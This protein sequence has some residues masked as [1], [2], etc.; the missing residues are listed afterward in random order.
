MERVELEACP[1]PTITHYS[2]TPDTPI[3]MTNV[4]SQIRKECHRHS[5]NHKGN[6]HR[7][8]QTIIIR[9]QYEWN[10]IFRHRSNGG[11]RKDY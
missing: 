9:T 11:S 7:G 3:A 6:S 1:V 2:Q 4:Y 10:N 8:E 5:F